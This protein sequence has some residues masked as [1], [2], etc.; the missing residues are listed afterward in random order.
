MSLNLNAADLLQQ[1]KELLQ[2]GS[3]T[4]VVNV[5]STDRGWQK[6]AVD[7]VAELHYMLAV[8]HRKLEAYDEALNQLEQVLGLQANYARAWQEKGFNYQ[9]INSA[10]KA[11]HSFKQAVAINP[12]LIACWRQLALGYKASNRMVEANFALRQFTFLNHLPVELQTVTSLYHEKKFYRAEQICRHY[13]QANPKDIE[14]MRLL[15]KLGI[16]SKVM[17]DAEFL[18]ESC[19]EFEPEHYDARVDYTVLLLRRQKFEKALEQVQ[20][21]LPIKPQD[22]QLNILHADALVG[23]GETKQ[24]LSLY[25]QVLDKNPSN[26]YPRLTLGHAQKTLGDIDTAIACYQSAYQHKPDFGDAYWS[27]ANLKTYRFSDVELESMRLQEASSGIEVIDRIHFCFA[28]GKCL[29]DRGQFAG[30]ILFKNIINAFVGSRQALGLRQLSKRFHAHIEYCTPSLF[31]EKKG[32]GYADDA[33]IFIVG[34]PRA[35]STLLEQILASHSQIDGTMELP[36]IL[37][38]AYKL[39]GRSRLDH[40]QRYPRVLHEMGEQQLRGLGEKF[41][42][43]TRVFRGGATHFIDKMPNNFIHI[44]LIKTILPNSKIIDARR[45]PMGCCFS[46]FK[47]LFGEGQ[48]F[49]YGLTEIGTYY[50]SYVELM[51]HWDQVLPGQILRVQYEDVVADLESQVRRMLEFLKLPFETA[52][53]DY[54]KTE[55]DVRTPSA[56]QVRQPIYK[57]GLEQWRNF[58][59]HLQPLREALGEELLKRYPTH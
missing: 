54:H 24:A 23:V 27:L 18:L 16:E 42:E 29:E 45:H 56:E 41:I 19:V 58:E 25:Q 12:A 6:L 49:S 39:Q 47:Q 13:M 38:M 11:E 28:L 17:D 50:R 35:G 55:R 44:G 53:L 21:L 30:R 33:P 36:N 8:S 43:E 57:G 26:H 5:L 9:A 10:E 37:G 46:G 59:D 31:A 15:A 14:G 48:V 1:I 20:V 22:M 32:L 52:C 3:F 2:A 40:E 4:Q 51:D 7:E 34:M